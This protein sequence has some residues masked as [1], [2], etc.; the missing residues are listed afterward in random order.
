[1]NFVAI[2]DSHGIAAAFMASHAIVD[3][4]FGKEDCVTDQENVSSANLNPGLSLQRQ[5]QG[6]PTSESLGLRLSSA[7]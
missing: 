3:R 2:W 6:R 5:V 4:W 1:M 7:W